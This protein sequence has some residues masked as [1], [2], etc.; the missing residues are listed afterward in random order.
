MLWTLMRFRFRLR[1]PACPV[2]AIVAALTLSTLTPLAALAQ[3]DPHA[4]MTASETAEASAAAAPTPARATQTIVEKETASVTEHTARIGNE[5]L[6]YTATAGTLL[7]RNAKGEP[8]ASM[9]YVAYTVQPHHGAP[10]PLTFLFNGGPGAGSM[11]LLIG[12]LGPKRVQTQSPAATPPAPY[13]LADNPDSLLDK[14]DLVFVDAVGTGFSRPAGNTS[15]KRFYSVDG[16]LDAFV[17]FIERYLSVN[18]RWN[19]PKFLLG[20]SYGA[21]RAAMLAYRLGQQQIALNGVALLSSVLNAYVHAPGYDLADVGYLPSYAA[22]AWYHHKL[23]EPRPPD[24]PA[25]LD[26][27][28]S[29]AAGPYKSALAK[30]DALPDNERNAI[31]AQVARYT[32]LDERYVIASHLR[33]RPSHFRKQLLRDEARSVGRYDGRFEGIESDPASDSSD[34][35]ASEK[36]ITSAFDAAFHDHLAH[37]LRYQVSLSYRVFSD[38]VLDSWVWKHHEWWGESLELP[39]PAGDLAE[40]MR[41]NPQ[42][43]VFSANGYFDVATPF[44]STEYDLAHMGLDSTLRAN[45]TITHYAS[46]HMI[47]VDD[48]ALQ[49]LKADL[50]HFYDAATRSVQR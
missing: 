37:D 44:F 39:Y 20:E 4:S 12:S 28:R 41:Q 38:T 18:Q 19:S 47:Y 24:L 17:R 7:L 32:G 25:F 46:G 40:A 5:R 8:D 13:T 9:F 21:S 14:T 49:A 48:A 26:E 45:I 2:A 31:A 36:Y 43:R 11:F 6:R 15:G 23:G 50:A 3:D 34:Y 10:R 29:F 35:D 27:V 33:I 22:V 16:D 1:S 42:L 30:G